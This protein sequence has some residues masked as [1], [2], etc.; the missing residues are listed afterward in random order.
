MIKRVVLLAIL[1][2]SLPLALSSAQELPPEIELALADLNQSLGTELTLDQLAFWSWDEDFYPDSSLGCPSPD[3]MYAQV[4]TRGYQFLLTYEG[5]TYD[6]RAASDSGQ[7]TYCGSFPAEPDIAST[8]EAAEG[9]APVPPGMA[10]ITPDNADQIEQ[11]AQVD[12]EFAGLMGWSPSGNSLVVA[13]GESGLMRF[14]AANLGAEPERIPLNAPVTSLTFGYAAPVA[15][16]VVGDLNG[17]VTRFPIEPTGFDALVMQPETGMPLSVNAV[18]INPALTVIASATGSASALQDAADNAVRLWDASS[19]AELAR[20]EH[21]APVRSIVYS[22][23]GALLAAG[24]EN[25]AVHIWDVAS[26]Q[27]IATLLG[28]TGAVRALAFN[29]EGSALASASMDGTVRLWNVSGTPEDYAQ[30]SLF[31]SGENYP[32]T[33]IAFN[34]EGTLLASAGGDPDAETIDAQ[35]RLWDLTAEAGGAPLVLLDG[36]MT[37]VGSLAF[38]PDGAY[39][40]SAGNDGTIRLW[41][42][43]ETAAAG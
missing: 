37:T 21:D 14:D 39:L 29:V 32:V 35:I 43:A 4:L 33:A 1:L 24:D 17:A 7:V 42:L 28:H 18:A 40:A 6:Y 36:H 22:P 3:V 34:P 30:I 9:G 26:E 11:V 19:G 12:G 31:D 25:G 27:E 13:D 41:G 10:P 20:L 38:S 23:D 8:L 5:T 15:F 16:M 2:F